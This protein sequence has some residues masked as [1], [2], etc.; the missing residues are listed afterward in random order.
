MLY[1]KIKIK[2]SKMRISMKV[3]FDMIKEVLFLNIR[4]FQ[5]KEYF[6]IFI[7]KSFHF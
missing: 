5:S 3:I 1:P 2:K 4:L 6:L 7:K